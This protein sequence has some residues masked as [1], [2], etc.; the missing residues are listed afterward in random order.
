MLELPHAQKREEVSTKEGRKDPSILSE[1]TLESLVRKLE[2]ENASVDVTLGNVAD[3][4]ELKEFSLEG[5]DHTN[6]P[7]NQEGKIGQGKQATKDRCHNTPCQR[8]LKD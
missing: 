7:T 4:G 8:T 6:E 1:K 5:I 3:I 2:F